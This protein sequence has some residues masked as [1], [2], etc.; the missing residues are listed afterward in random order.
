M[1]KIDN[2][3]LSL[4][5]E[6]R[7]KLTKLFNNKRTSQLR[8][9]II[10]EIFNQEGGEPFIYHNGTNYVK[11]PTKN[12]ENEVVY[13]TYYLLMDG[14]NILSAHNITE[15]LEDNYNHIN[16]NNLD[17][18][19]EYIHLFRGMEIHNYVKSI[20][21]ICTFGV[22][23]KTDEI[24]GYKFFSYRKDNIKG[25]LLFI[26]DPN[27]NELPYRQYLSLHSYINIYDN[28]QRLSICKP[29]FAENI[30]LSTAIYNKKF[31]Y[32]YV[33]AS[34]LNAAISC[35]DYGYYNAGYKY[36]I[37][38]FNN[39]VY[40]TDLFIKIKNLCKRSE[41]HNVNIKEINK[42]FLYFKD[43]TNLYLTKFT[44]VTCKLTEDLYKKYNLKI[45]DSP[46]TWCT[47]L[48]KHILKDEEWCTPE[49][50]SILHYNEEKKKYLP[51]NIEENPGVKQIRALIIPT[52]IYANQ[53]NDIYILFDRDEIV[54][55]ILK[56][57]NE[58]RKIQMEPFVDIYRFPS[59]R[60]ISV[61]N[62]YIDKYDKND[63][64][65][66]E[67]TS[68]SDNYTDDTEGSEVSE[69]SEVSE[70]SDNNTIENQDSEDNLSDIKE[71]EIEIEIEENEYTENAE[72][73]DD[74]I[75]D[76]EEI[77]D[78]NEEEF[79]EENN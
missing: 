28:F 66:E 1:S 18:E 79:E 38:H 70:A 36:R 75:E 37:S 57:K 78:E 9:D 71:N 33:V 68:E 65:D 27:K 43:L 50:F 19:N 4:Y 32:C 20:A 74:Q 58:H 34:D 23:K 24:V 22:Y 41:K 14:N 53:L 67:H 8:K 12:E 13:V 49:L 39:N 55:D 59:E 46:S 62:E 21:L 52:D 15:W 7:H 45:K 17:L 25:N 61:K 72:D 54:N 56:S 2:L 3:A 5:N 77:S 51:I 44:L 6:D 42:R 11:D 40:N 35:Y 47:L 69:V 64:S 30:K 31:F 73:V 10:R 76:E 26:Q 48:Y 63:K 29:L 16:Y 60:Q